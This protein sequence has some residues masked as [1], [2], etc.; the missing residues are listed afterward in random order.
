MKNNHGLDSR[1]FKEKLGQIVRD[2]DHY[3]PS[4][5]ARAL[6]RLAATAAHQ[7]TSLE[8]AVK[9]ATEQSE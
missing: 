4:E 3:T 1:Y 5:M 2:A 7:R 9:H 8:W 6:E